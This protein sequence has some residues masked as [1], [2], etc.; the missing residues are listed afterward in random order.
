[1]TKKPM[2]L[3]AASAA[4]LLFVTLSPGLLAQEVAPTAPAMPTAPA[5]Q[6]APANP[7]APAQPAP[8]AAVAPQAAATLYADLVAAAPPP[9]EIVPPE[10]VMPGVEPFA[11][12][13]FQ[14]GNFLGVSVEEVTR[15]T[16][17]RYGMTGEPRGLV[18][19]SVIKGSPA[20]R[21]GLREGDV[22]L[23][24]DGEPVNTY[25]KLNRLIDESSPEHNARLSVRR[26]GGGEQEINVTLGKREGV[27]QLFGNGEVWRADELRRRAEEL[28]GQGERSR[29][30]GEAAR[31]QAEEMRR[32]AEELRRNN[33][34]NFFSFGSFSGRR[35]GVTTSALGK[36]L[37]DY[38]GVQRGLLISSVVEGSP[39]DRAGLKAGDIITEVDGERIG[40]TE[41]L[42]RV[43]NRREQGD[44]TLTIVRDRK[45]RTV[46]VTPERREP[47]FVTPSARLLPL[48]RMERLGAAARTLT[49]KVA[50]IAP[51]TLVTP[52]V[53]TLPKL[54]PT[55]PPLVRG[56][57]L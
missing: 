6:A 49:P 38:F 29:E 37:A 19:R 25:R 4:F 45:T 2:K 24:F 17:G 22:I 54:T 56:R 50:P 33:N 12:S 27:S 48:T 44:V 34:E 51:R 26:S 30:R 43:I 3:S 53:Y 9:Q 52:R 5:Q 21:A 10:A 13:L 55:R 16:M 14:G 15:E 40:E 11:F 28:R 8:P 1:M 36:Q 57:V 35:I 46:R 47:V 7:S 31:R 23:R 20:E 18:I 42:S 41:E 39:A 32:R